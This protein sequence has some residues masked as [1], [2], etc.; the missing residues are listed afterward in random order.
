M[1]RL[2]TIQ[3]TPLRTLLEQL[4]F[5]G[6]GA[7]LRQIDRTEALAAELDPAF[8]YPIKFVLQRITG[9][10]GDRP[11][12]GSLGEVVPGTDLF[13][14]LS[15][16]VE[17]L[18]A[19]AQL[20]PAEL[21]PGWLTI[22]QLSERWGVTRRTI[23]R[24]RRRGLVARRVHH[25]GGVV[26]MVFTESAV[27]AFE[28]NHAK[29]L[30]RAREFSRIE[31]EEAA[32]F[33]RLAER[34]QQ[35][36]GWSATVVAGRLAARFGRSREAV[37][38][39]LQRGDG[40]RTA[41]LV[42][43]ERLDDAQRAALLNAWNSG[44]R[45]RTIAAQFEI[46]PTSVARIVAEQNA[47]T[48]LRPLRQW[49]AGLEELH[50]PEY[51]ENTEPLRHEP[52]HAIGIETAWPTDLAALLEAAQRARPMPIQLERER[53]R[54]ALTVPH[55]VLSEIEAL[56][57]RSPSWTQVDAWTTRLR[58][59]LMLKRSVAHALF[60]VMLRALHERLGHS[61]EDLS[62]AHSAEVYRAAIEAV[63]TALDRFGQGHGQRAA[64]QVSQAI[65]KRV[66]TPPSILGNPTTTRAKPLTRLP[67]A[68]TLLAPW[69]E[70]VAL[71][72]AFCSLIR[73]IL[74]GLVEP[75]EGVTTE[76]AQAIAARH[77]MNTSMPI[78]AAELAQ[79]L[80]ATR[81]A[82]L[83]AERRL[84]AAACESRPGDTTR[85]PNQSVKRTD[86]AN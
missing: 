41:R 78:T 77:G 26:Q 18:C 85:S 83:D 9:Y 69:A 49:A 13:A 35:R 30:N 42:V 37:R 32:R 39:I 15:A 64:G 23:E 34:Y 27:N 54:L 17:H 19:K 24:H 2:S 31:P 50:V 56:H 38:Q 4:R 47:R 74:A 29:L 65:T 44:Q 76:L 79:R 28:T 60:G 43:R 16:L 68:D 72:R 84:R 12:D 70:G 59:A 55:S 75:P 80:G 58:H 63:G 52:R 40:N 61:L 53:C 25:A 7:L 66:D 45:T 57:G 46:A 22:E 36:L 1:P 86:V 62:P 81:R 82:V 71:P 51:A 3:S 14:D 6:R 8:A 21:P 73:G 10:R 33:V 5:G 48:I 11:T 67:E 20:S